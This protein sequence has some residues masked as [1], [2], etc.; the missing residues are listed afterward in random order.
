MK[1]LSVLV[2]VYNEAPILPELLLRLDATLSKQNIDY[3]V[4]AIDDRSS[5]GSLEVLRILS[6]KFPL[7]AFS[8]KGVQGKALSLI[9]I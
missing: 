9:H 1:Q 4:I 7:K 8:K 2:P 5:D 6:K 3:E